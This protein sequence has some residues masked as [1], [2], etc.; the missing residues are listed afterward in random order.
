MV[1]V[2]SRSSWEA[3]SQA[4]LRPGVGSGIIGEVQHRGLSP[5]LLRATAMKLSVI[6]PAFNEEK[7]LP[8]C[9]A[10]VAAALRACSAP[11]WSAEV[12]VCD[13]NSTD[14]TAEVARAG[15]AAVVF[16]PINQISRAR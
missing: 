8:G 12:I 9:L 7:L 16:E 14:R 4:Y 15:G 6:L 1:N 10:S 3:Q 2:Q 5:G 13:N 11:D